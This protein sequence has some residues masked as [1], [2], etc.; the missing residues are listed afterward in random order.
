VTAAVIAAAS[1]AAY[2]PLALPAY[3]AFRGARCNME[4]HTERGTD[5]HVGELEVY[6]PPMLDEIGGFTAL[7]RFEAAGSTLDRF[8][9]RS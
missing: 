1:G 7:T 4:T 5:I 2:A 3:V 9:F 8:G 6:E